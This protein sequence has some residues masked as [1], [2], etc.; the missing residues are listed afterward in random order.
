MAWEAEYTDEFEAWWDTLTPDQ[1]ERVTAAVEIL[2]ESG[3]TLGRPI[4]DRIASS[5]YQNMK[6]LRVSEDGD[7]RVL[8]AFGPRRQPIL[9]IGG[10]K[11]GTWSDWYREHVPIADRL[12]ARYLEEIDKE[13]DRSK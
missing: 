10:D 8:F 9:L 4:V 11:E 7:L 2:E 3:P 1:Q 5:Q 13:V 6:E 12:Y